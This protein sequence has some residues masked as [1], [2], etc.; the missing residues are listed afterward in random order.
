V[1]GV[2]CR[3]NVDSTAVTEHSRKYVLLLLPA[4][5]WSE[6]GLCRYIYTMLHNCVLHVYINRSL[7]ACVRAF[8][9]L[10][11][12]VHWCCCSSGGGGVKACEVCVCVCVCVC[13]W[14]FTS[15]QLY[16]CV[17]AVV[18]SF[19]LLVWFGFVLVWFGIVCCVYTNNRVWPSRIRSFT[20]C[21]TGGACDCPIHVDIGMPRSLCEPI[22]HASL[23]RLA[24]FAG[25]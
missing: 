17:C 15:F 8:C 2:S 1:F 6:C 5:R 16:L 3:R 18:C 23:P 7:C 24:A 10:C 20:S 22:A 25:D 9:V 11:V 21:D 12:R 13:V 14:R 4:Q 19:V